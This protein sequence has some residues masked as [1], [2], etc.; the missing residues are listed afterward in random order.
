MSNIVPFPNSTTQ[1]LRCGEVCRRGTPDPSKQA[2]HQAQEGF[3]PAC[4]I[5]K[6]LRSV[7]PIRAMIDGDR[8]RKPLGP[9]I[10]LDHAWRET[11][12]RPVLAGVLAHTQLPEDSINWLNVVAHWGQP[13]PPGREPGLLF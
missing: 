8:G 12:L 11:V 1:C 4:M 6:F 7:E 5:E 10:F 3:C 13:Y 9:E 2:I